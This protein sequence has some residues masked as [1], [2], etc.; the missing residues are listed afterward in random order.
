MVRWKMSCQLMEEL[1]V[2]AGRSVATG[3][4]C[5]NL[6]PCHF[7]CCLPTPHPLHLH[8]SSSPPPP[9]PPSIPNTRTPLP[10]PTAVCDKL[11]LAVDLLVVKSVPRAGVKEG[12]AG[13]D[14]DA[15]SRPSL[16]L[17]S[18]RTPGTPS[19]PNP[20]TTHTHTR[21]ATKSVLRCCGGNWYSVQWDLIRLDVVHV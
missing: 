9:P 11:L 14:E 21:A 17:L 6:L 12:W 18:S 8:L 7:F 20:T 3:A 15:A 2:A 4:M 1:P 19:N 10:L 16:Y 5:V 13:E